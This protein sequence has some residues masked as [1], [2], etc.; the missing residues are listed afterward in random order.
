MVKMQITNWEVAEEARNLL[1][2]GEPILRVAVDHHPQTSLGP[3]TLS[4][5]SRKSLPN[6]AVL[7]VSLCG[8][9]FS[10]QMAELRNNPLLYGLFLH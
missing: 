7:L 8:E 5:L 3:S 9:L 10:L 6:T 1:L 2:Q 4:L